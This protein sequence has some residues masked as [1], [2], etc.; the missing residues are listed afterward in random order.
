MKKIPK[1][2]LQLTNDNE[3]DSSKLKNK[4]VLFFYPK[5]LTG[6]CSVEVAEFQKYLTKFN[7]NETSTYLPGKKVNLG[8][9][10]KGGSYIL[11][12]AE[13]KTSEIEFID[14]NVNS[15]RNDLKKEI[16][17]FNSRDFDEISKFSIEN[18]SSIKDF[19][20]SCI[21]IFSI[22]IFLL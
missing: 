2:K 14:N 1:I 4:T 15:I 17:F 13:M 18:L 5:A 7:F 16:K 11:L 9:D 8:L 20:E 12:Q 22:S 6:G 21:F 3:F 19:N 10:L